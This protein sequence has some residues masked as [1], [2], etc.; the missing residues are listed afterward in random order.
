MYFAAESK[1]P[2]AQLVSD[3]WASHSL[4][5]GDWRLETGDWRERVRERR[6]LLA[7]LFC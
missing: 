6:Y 2:T 7:C 5:T 4:E 1:D 3:D